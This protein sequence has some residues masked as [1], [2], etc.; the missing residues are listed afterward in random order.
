MPGPNSAPNGDRGLVRGSR[1]EEF[2]WCKSCNAAQK[3]RGEKVTTF[4]RRDHDIFHGRL[5]T[6][7][8]D[9]GS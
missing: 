1:Y 9:S 5:R 3:N 4:P 2:V 7:K 8:T 6:G